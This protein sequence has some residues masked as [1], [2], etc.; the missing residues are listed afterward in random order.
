[1]G[2]SER[3][4]GHE[5]LHTGDGVTDCLCSATFLCGSFEDV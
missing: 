2:K 4:E 5:A 3:V 1:M